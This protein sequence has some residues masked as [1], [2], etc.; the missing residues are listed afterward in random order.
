MSCVSHYDARKATRRL[1]SGFGEAGFIGRGRRWQAAFPEV[2]WTIEID[3]P[4]GRRLLGIDLKADFAAVPARP[5]LLVHFDNEDRDRYTR[6]E[7]GRAMQLDS[8]LD[9]NKR[10]DIF[11]A[12]G[13]EVVSFIGQL[14][15]LASIR[16][17]YAQGQFEN[18]FIHKDARRSLES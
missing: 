4:P 15:S 7:I 13:A 10:S 2:V 8:Q 5:A 1:S 18:S 6:F 9:E 12:L 17:A 14:D 11:D 3:Q 16:N